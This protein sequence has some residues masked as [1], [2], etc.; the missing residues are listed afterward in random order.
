[1]KKKSHLK[2][3][4]GSAALTLLTIL[5]FFFLYWTI[6]VMIAFSFNNQDHNYYW[7]GFTLKWYV[8]LFTNSSIMKYVSTS[9]IVAVV[10]T[11]VS[12]IIGTVGAVG[13]QRF[14][15]KLKK[16]INN[17]LYIP[18]VIPEIVLGISLLMLFETT[19]FPLGTA[20]MILA[21]C[22]FC[23]PFVLVTVRGR[24]AG[25]DMSAEEAS[26]DLGANRLQTLIKVTIPMLMPAII[27]A[28]FL[29]FTL[30]IDDVIISNFVAGSRTTT[31]P[32]KVLSTVRSGLTPEINALY[33][34]M[35]A[36]II[37]G[38]LCN[39]LLQRILRKKEVL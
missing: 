7:A 5:V 3:K 24:I 2:G 15:F 29:A 11:V 17:S 28:T 18:I 25:M 16:L 27:S 30:S 4:I 32:V 22:T 12:V 35:I 39:S 10:S 19:D 23:I 26:Y 9:I 36:I 37:V 31:L 20:A 8:K 38:M 21:H 33:T 6:F 34:I 1:M 13:L 14:E